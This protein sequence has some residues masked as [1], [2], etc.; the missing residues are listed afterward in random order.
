MILVLRL[1]VGKEMDHLF[2]NKTLMNFH[3][4]NMTMEYMH[5]TENSCVNISIYLWDM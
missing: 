1:M 3:G 5:Y 2:I 4:E